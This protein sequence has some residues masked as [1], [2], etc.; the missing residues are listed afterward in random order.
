MLVRHDDGQIVFEVFELSP[1]NEVVVSTK[2][3]LRRHFPQAAVSISLKTFGKYD[4]K[5]AFATT[6]AKM[7]HQV[8][9]ETVPQ[10]IKA[11]QSHDEE[12][13]TTDPR[14]VT[15]FL[16]SFLRA[17]GSAAQVSG[18]WKRTREE[19]LWSHPHKTPWRRTAIWL[20][21]RVSLQLTFSRL[22]SNPSSGSPLDLY[23]RFQIFLMSRILPAACHQQFSSHFLYAM[24]SKMAQR[25]LKLGLETQE[26]WMKPVAR[27]MQATTNRIE[28]RWRAIRETDEKNLNITRL[29]NLNV[30]EDLPFLLPELDS[31]IQSIS[32]RQQ[33]NILMEFEPN[34]Q[35]LTTVP[36][37]LPSLDDIKSDDPYLIYHLLAFEDW[38]ENC[39]DS[40]L[41][42]RMADENTTKAVNHIMRKYH[43]LAMVEYVDIPE[44]VSVMILTL[45]ELW[46]ACDKSAIV[47]HPQLADYDNEVPEGIFCS[48]LFRLG[49]DLARLYRAEEYLGRRSASAEP[50]GFPSIFTSFGRPRSFSVRYFASSRRL[51]SLQSRIEKHAQAQR[52]KK[53]DELE[54]LKAKYRRLMKKY[55][56]GKCENKTS[57]DEDGDEFI[58]HHPQCGRCAFK[59]EAIAISIQVHEWPLPAKKLEAQSVVFE[60]DPPLAFCAWRDC[61]AFLINSVLRCLPSEKGQPRAKHTLANYHGLQKYKVDKVSE[62][63]VMLLSEDKPH[64]SMH[65]RK[66]KGTIISTTEEDV[67][68]NNGLRW[69][70]YSSDLQ[71]L[72]VGRD[73]GRN[74][75]SINTFSATDDISR[76]CTFELPDRAASVQEFLHR[77][78]N[79]PDGHEPNVV[80]ASQHR[81]PPHFALDEFR[82]L[83]SLPLGQNIQWM[84]VLVQLSV[85]S[86]DWKKAETAL[87]IRQI[88]Q[89][90]GP[91]SED[92]KS[93]RA[94][95]EMLKDPRF[96][97]SVL[98]NLE[99]SLNRVKENWESCHAVGTFS[100]IAGRL[101]TFGP[102]D[103]WPKCL[104]LLSSC[105]QICWRWLQT[106]LQK[107]DATDESIQRSRLLE[108]VLDIALICADTF[109]IDQAFLTTLMSTTTEA[110]ILLRCFLAIQNTRSIL[111][112]EDKLQVALLHHWQQLAF[113]VAPV[114][115][116]RIADFE[117]P[118]LDEAISEYWPGFKPSSHWRIADDAGYWLKST[119]RDE[120][121]GSS[122]PVFFNLLTGELLV[123]GRPLDRLPSSLKEHPQYEGFF[124]KSQLDVAPSAEPGMEFSCRNLFS[125]Y[126][127]HL[128]L[129]DAIGDSFTQDIRLRASRD[130]IV[131]DLIPARL[132]EEK[133]PSSFFEDFFHWYNHNDNTIEM[134][135]SSQPWEINSMNWLLFEHQGHWRLRKGESTYLVNPYSTIATEVSKIFSRL[136][137]QSGLQIY[138]EKEAN[139]LVIDIPRLQL[140]FQ[141]KHQTYEIRSCQFRGM[142]V[143]DSQKIGALIGLKNKLVLCDVS[144]PKSRVVLIP[145]GDVKYARS[146]DPTE[147]TFHVKVTINDSR[148]CKVQVYTLEEHIGQLSGNGTLQSKLL[149]AY[150]HA[151]TSYCLPDFLTEHTGT[152]QAINILRSEGVRSFSY[153]TQENIDILLKISELSPSRTYHPPHLKSMQSVKWLSSLTPL[154]QPGDFLQ[155]VTSIFQQAR[156]TAFFYPDKYIEPQPLER[157]DRPLL[158]R[159]NI[160]SSTFRT[161][162]FGAESYT[163]EGDVKY[164]SRNQG[165]QPEP[166]QRAFEVVSA[167]ANGTIALFRPLDDDMAEYIYHLLSNSEEL[168]A[169]PSPLEVGDLQYDCRWLEPPHDILPAI[170]CRFHYTMQGGLSGLNKYH[171][172]LCLAAMGYSKHANLAVVQVLT[173]IATVPALQ[174]IKIPRD[175]PLILSKGKDVDL[176]SIR[177]LISDRALEYAHCPERKMRKE[178]SESKA[179]ALKRRKALHK[180]NLDRC[181]E[182]LA[183]DFHKQWPRQAPNVPSDDSFMSYIDMHAVM[184]DIKIL[185]RHWHDNEAFAHYLG[186]VHDTLREI[187]V[188]P[189]KHPTDSFIRARYTDQATARFISVGDIFQRFSPEPLQDWD[190]D[191]EI[192]SLVIPEQTMTGSRLDDLLERLSPRARSS[193]ERQYLADLRESSSSLA[194]RVQKYA[195]TKDAGELREFLVSYRDTALSFVDAAYESMITDAGRQQ[196]ADKVRSK[197]FTPISLAAT[198]YQWPR[199]CNRLLLQQLNRHHWS[200]L[201]EDWQEAIVG[202]GLLLTEYQ[203]AERLLRNVHD[204]ANLIRELQNEGHKNWDPIE[205]PESLLLEIESGIMIRDVQEEIASKMRSPPDSQNSV[206]QLNMGEGKSSVIIPIVASYLADKTH[207][208]RVICTKPQSEQMFEM[209]VSKLG[210]LI[211]RRV[212]RMPF[213]RALNIAVEEIEKIM[214]LIEECKLNGGILL[215]QPE[216]ILS[217]QLLAL[218]TAMNEG[219]SIVKL[220]TELL[221]AQRFLN[222]HTRDLVDESDENLSTKLELIY[223]MGQQRPIEHGPDRW[224]LIQEILGL[225]LD[226]VPELQRSSPQSVECVDQ[227]DSS[228]PRTRILTPEATTTLAAMLATRICGEGV[229]GLP[230][231]RQPQGFIS[232]LQ[233]YLCEPDL[234]PQ[235]VHA[236]EDTDFWNPSTS[237]NILLIRGLLAGGVFGFAFGQKRWRVNYGLDPAR[238]PETRLAVPYFAKDCPTSRS[239]F[240]HPDVV[241]VLTCLC[242]YYEGLSDDYLFEAFNHLLQ[243]DQ[244]ELEY[245]A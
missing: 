236:V 75:S 190:H 66:R 143:D 77:P 97:R 16:M 155:L 72:L 125:G 211:G 146:G 227:S 76:L 139:L 221:K 99:V 47:V 172:M 13:D 49:K 27:E 71:L 48:L 187:T 58:E 219:S 116:R 53:L 39:L 92:I 232:S 142:R 102:E 224:L 128:G 185:F 90:V 95:F 220:S 147:D 153:L 184:I 229:T 129:E 91:R 182:S 7:S 132:F 193:Q 57:E 119:S 164:L 30:E 98:D 195:L 101:L 222:Q 32:Q 144:D 68:V 216:H 194:N 127:I 109:D 215:T 93:P 244:A 6:L 137:T 191:P 70:Y 156:K 171:I 225:L 231:S 131:Y 20:L 106:L 12:R 35:L 134:R 117:C 50:K 160:R 33:L 126:E 11:E 45:V 17:N 85:P 179:A 25:I 51:L 55:D 64:E 104:K 206:M 124:G 108:K 245:Q 100:H 196:N 81:C 136:E 63:T 61:T 202:W 170:W 158:L 115:S 14:I 165:Q 145:E 217:F 28:K 105:R 150:L 52:N 8:V 122:M 169:P 234:S 218:E 44:G 121:R 141:M 233:Y 209:L 67:C 176:D 43:S 157:L 239:E 148:P 41:Q 189:I 210:G 207:L 159:D 133:L 5:D 15:E 175:G 3:C 19:V 120:R 166:A 94:S 135:P 152:E 86:V 60:L 223:T 203:R 208:V 201:P 113:R 82:S 114:L 230:I 88:S 26:D 65:R 243:A 29:S 151:L 173:A 228:V 59:N 9:A 74:E 4:F 36:D 212:L 38:V 18:M 240:S 107:V 118:C 238:R 140:T 40:W 163:R 186:V 78:A 46:I 235:E 84:N 42:A 22:S 226:C 130:D 21:I 111:Q 154:S 241:I 183:Q 177:A 168:L 73:E 56:E 162:G 123:N 214:G 110:M 161:S 87:F 197:S 103:M 198:A 2:G 83:C 180:E 89:Q 188:V 174:R 79:R 213:S 96:V 69:K 54:E 138:Y 80:I 242:Y 181:V 37:C 34:S 62:Q 237:Q 149:L 200:D 31:Y 204:E 167:I 1:T 205:S 10:T 112:K 24:N 23:K 199:F 192:K 178:A